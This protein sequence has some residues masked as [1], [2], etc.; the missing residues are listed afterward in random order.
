MGLPL[1][2]L[3]GIFDSLKVEMQHALDIDFWNTFDPFSAHGR[4]RF[5]QS[6]GF[7]EWTETLRSMG[8]V[9]SSWH[10]LARRLL[11]HNIVARHGLSRALVQ[12]PLF[13]GWTQE[14]YVSFIDPIPIDQDYLLPDLCGRIPN[15]RLVSFSLPEDSVQLDSLTAVICKG[16]SMLTVV[17]DIA[18]LGDEFL[19]SLIQLLSETQHPTLRTLRFFLQTPSFKIESDMLPQSLSPLVALS[20][21]C[22]IHVAYDGRRGTTDALA[23]LGRVSAVSWTRDPIQSGS[24]FSLHHLRLEPSPSIPLGNA[25][26]DGMLRSAR[27]ADFDVFIYGASKGSYTDGIVSASISKSCRTSSS[28]CKLTLRNK[29]SPALGDFSQLLSSARAQVSPSVQELVLVTTLWSRGYVEGD[30]LKARI[31]SDD[32]QLS[33]VLGP[34][35]IPGLRVLRV[36]LNEW[37]LPPQFIE[38]IVA[39]NTGRFGGGEDVAEQVGQYGFL[40]PQC[41]QKCKERCI[42]FLVDIVF[43]AESWH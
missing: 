17:E 19:D 33:L 22:S 36:F 18:F 25:A 21:L 20:S 27:H 13:G 14:L 23:T 35:M 31:A 39:E 1:V 4:D 2:V 7:Q 32:A 5:S 30:P 3:L 15:V 28:A 10:T 11:G 6:T 8:L 38:Q 16:V 26:I 9:H 29:W 12:S 34:G 42:D 37:V 24:T 40:L 43:S 41:V